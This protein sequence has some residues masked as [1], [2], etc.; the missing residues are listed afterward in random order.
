V[1]QITE[2]HGGRVEAAS[3]GI[4]KGSRFSVWFPLYGELPAAASEQPEAARHSIGGL[5]ILLIDDME[6]L[7]ASFKMLLEF[8]GATV[9][10]AT[11]AGDA[12]KILDRQEVDLVISDIAMPDMDGHMFIEKVRQLEKHANLPAIA[13]SGMGRPKDI[14]RAREA[15][16]SAHLSKPVSMPDL[17]KTVQDL[18]IR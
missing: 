2:L 9:Y 11:R 10:T 12:L 4:G 8:E 5:R 6:D 3:E 14:E 15:G 1:R 17:I 13:V 7:I 18:L 16:F